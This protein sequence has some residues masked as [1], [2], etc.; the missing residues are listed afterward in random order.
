[1]KTQVKEMKLIFTEELP[2]E[3][4]F[5]W[6]TNFGEHTPTVLEVKKDT[7]GALWADNGEYTFK[8]EPPDPQK[9]MELFGDEEDP[10]VEGK[11]KFGDELWCRIPNPYL[12]NRKK[13]VKSSCY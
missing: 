5:Y 4:G 3:P 12:P 2:K 7:D 1:M 9:E 13:Q 6:W 8:I 11:Y 10:P